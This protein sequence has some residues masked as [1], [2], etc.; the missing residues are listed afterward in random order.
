[1]E[2]PVLAL[3]RHAG[4]HGQRPLL[5]L[6]GTQR[7]HGIRAAYDPRRKSDGLT[8][9]QAANVAPVVRRQIAQWAIRFM[10]R[11]ARHLAT[12]PAAKHPP[13]DISHVSVR[14]RRRCS[15]RQ[16]SLD[17]ADELRPRGLARKSAYDFP[18]Q[19]HELGI[20]NRGGDAAPLV[21]GC[22]SIVTAVQDKGRDGYLRQ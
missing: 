17:L 12:N 11:R 16:E 5:G 2:C 18:V 19:S 15:V 20:R 8:L 6:D 13:C 14:L 21:K 9:N 22:C 1:M 7:G 3:L 10:E 4:A